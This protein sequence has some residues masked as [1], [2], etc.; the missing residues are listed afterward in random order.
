MPI[1]AI[2]HHGSDGGQRAGAVGGAVAGGGRG[3]LHLVDAGGFASV[4]VDG[5]DFDGGFLHGHGV[6]DAPERPGRVSRG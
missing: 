5:A 2:L 6:G 1:D 3:D 4:A